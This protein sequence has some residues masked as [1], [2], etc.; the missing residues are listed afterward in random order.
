MFRHARE[1]KI[2]LIITKSISRF[3][4]NTKEILEVLQQL[5]ESGTTVY[6][7][8]EGVEVSKGLSSLVLETHAAMAQDFIE[9]VSNLVKFSYQKRLNEGRPYFHEMYG[10]DLVEPGGKDMVKINERKQK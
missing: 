6:F 3:S 8:R 5:K 7:E 1:G 2:D 9:G 10:Y 4:R